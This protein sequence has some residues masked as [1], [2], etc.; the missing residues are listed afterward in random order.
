MT[1]GYNVMF[2][3]KSI[4]YYAV[5]TIMTQDAFQMGLHDHNHKVISL[6]YQNK[7]N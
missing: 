1:Q 7:T 3:E 2:Y 6:T 4:C 5:V